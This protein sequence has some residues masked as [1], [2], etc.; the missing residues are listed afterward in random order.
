MIAGGE[1]YQGVTSGLRVQS[2]FGTA[3]WWQDQVQ[4][5]DREEY[6]P[7]FDLRFIGLENNPREKQ[8]GREGDAIGH[9]RAKHTVGGNQQRSDD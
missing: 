3:E 8:H 4:V 7:H 6:I 5:K 2:P 1:V 9:G